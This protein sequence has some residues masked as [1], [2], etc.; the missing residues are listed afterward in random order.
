[1]LGEENSGDASPIF[2][3][4]TSRPAPRVLAHVRWAA[5]PSRDRPLVTR[6]SGA[7]SLCALIQLM[8]VSSTWS[9]T[10]SFI[11]SCMRPCHW[12]ILLSFEPM[13]LYQLTSK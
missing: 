3:G 4:V 2:L 12:M 1:M 11:V 10:G 7:H 6:S 13:A 8:M 5:P 9:L